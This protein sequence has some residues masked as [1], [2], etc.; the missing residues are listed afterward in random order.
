MNEQFICLWLLDVCILADLIKLIFTILRLNP[1]HLVFI[2]LYY[3]DRYSFKT[4][5][6]NLRNISNALD[7]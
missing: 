5:L 7:C 6:D 2:I 3:T 4:D 1:F